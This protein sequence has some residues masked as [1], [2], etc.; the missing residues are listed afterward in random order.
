MSSLVPIILM[1][2]QAYLKTMDRLPNYDQ[3]QMKT[4]RKLMKK[5]DGLRK[6]KK[7]KYYDDKAVSDAYNNLLLHLRTIGADP[8]FSIQDL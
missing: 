1:L 7:G 3:R 6:Q 4:T 5:Y 2:G 8:R